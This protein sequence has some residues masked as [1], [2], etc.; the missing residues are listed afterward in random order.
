MS[1]PP[2]P[3]RP[4]PRQQVLFPETFPGK[5]RPAPHSS[6]GLA[7]W[8]DFGHGAKPLSW[9]KRCTIASAESAPPHVTRV[10]SQASRPAPV[11]THLVQTAAFYISASFQPR[12]Y[13]R[14]KGKEI[15]TRSMTSRGPGRHGGQRARGPRHPG[16]HAGPPRTPPNPV[17]PAR[18]SLSCSWPCLGQAASGQLM[19]VSNPS[20]IKS[21]TYCFRH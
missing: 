19:A 11:C 5:G 4:Q 16:K 21:S 14:S 1:C 3:G 6:Q 17:T 8:P 7:P 10:P 2:S 15:Q 20:L 9:A 12:P 18:A 13:T